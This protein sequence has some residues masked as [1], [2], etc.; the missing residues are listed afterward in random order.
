MSMNI[1]D[2][3]VAL[4]S[5]KWDIEC[6]NPSNVAKNNIYYSEKLADALTILLDIDQWRQ[7]VGTLKILFLAI[8][9]SVLFVKLQKMEPA[10]CSKSRVYKGLWCEGWARS[11]PHEWGRLAPAPQRL[12]SGPL[13]PY[14]E[15]WEY[16]KERLPVQESPLTP[17]CE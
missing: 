11:F 9:T 15:L 12:Y 16:S 1:A 4:D 2:T 14:N 10:K 5:L 6:N 7:K 13:F 17:S 8:N 3:I